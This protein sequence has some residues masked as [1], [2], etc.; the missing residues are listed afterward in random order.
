MNSDRPGITPGDVPQRD[1]PWYPDINDFA[2][3]FDGY[4]EFGGFEPLADF[5]EGARRAWVRDRSLPDNLRE[6]RALL[7]F[8][9]RGFRHTESEPEGDDLEFV[10]AIL[11]AIRNALS[12]GESVG[13]T[14]AVGDR[15]LQHVS[16]VENSRTLSQE[17]THLEDVTAGLKVAGIEP[18][19]PVEV[20]AVSWH[21]NT[22]VT[23]TYRHNDSVHER[24]LYRADEEQLEIVG[25]ANRWTFDAP[26]DDF[27]LA[28]EARRIQLAHLFDPMVAV[29]SSLIEPLPH[30]IQAVYGEMLHRHPLRFLLAD[31]PGAGKTIMAGLYI[32]ELMIRGDVERCLVVA[33]GSLVN[34]WQDELAE[35]FGLKFEILTRDAIEASH[36]GDPF[37]EKPLL[38]ARVDQVA[39]R[40]DL[41]ER[42][43]DTEWDLTVVDEAHKMSAQYFGR[44][45]RETKRYRLGRVLSRISRHFLLMTATP[46][47]GNHESF[48]L[49]LALIDPDRFAGRYRPGA[50]KK[51]DT[52][53]LMRRMIKEKLLRFDGRPLFPE[54]RA[55][56][57]NYDL[58][59]EEMDLYE[60]VTEYVR[61]EMNRAE[62]IKDGDGRR[63]NTVGF[64]LTVLQRRLASSPEAIYQSIRR[65]RG[66]LEDRI[67]EVQRGGRLSDLGLNVDK[68]GY[69]EDEEALED[70]EDL[71]VEELEDLEL[72]VAD[73]ASAA[74]TLTE[75]EAEVSTLKDL[76]KIAARVRASRSDTKW[77]QL[78]DLLSESPEMVDERGARR[79]LIIFTEHRD[80]LNYLVDRLRTYLGSERAVVAIHGGLAR[81]FRREVQL[82]FTQDKDVTI[83]V[84]TDAAGEGINLQRAHLVLNYDLPWNPNRIEQRFGR[85]HRIGQTEVCHM[86][87]LIAGQTR[88]GAVYVRLMEKIDR[89]R[90]A[91][92]GQVYDVLGQAIGGQQL[93][94]LLLDAIRY[95]DQPEVRARLD[96]VIDSTVSDGI[97]RLVQEHALSSEVM[98]AA[99]IDSIRQRMEEA[100]AKRLQP[101]Y[102]QTYFRKAFERFGGSTRDREPG[103][104][105]VMKTPHLIRSQRSRTSGVPLLSRYERITFEKD[106]VSVP[107]SPAAELITPGHRLLDATLAAT[108]DQLGQTLTRGAIL[109]DERP[110]APEPRAL[111]MMEH[112]IADP[113]PSRG[114]GHTVVSRRFEYAELMSDGTSASAS[115]APY[116]DYRPATED[117]I[118]VIRPMLGEE[119][120]SQDLE[121]RAKAL[122]IE[123]SVPTHLQ[124]V[125][126]ELSD[127]VEKV[128]AE[129][130]DRLTK[131]INY[132]DDRAR[133]L[134]EQVAAGKQPRINPERARQRAEELDRRRTE[135]LA[136]LELERNVKALPP[137]VVG[138]ALVVPW[139]W[140]EPTRAYPKQTKAVERR[141]VEAVL[142]AERELGR[143]PEEMPFNNPGFDIKSK[144][145]D[146]DLLFI[147]VKGRIEGA[148]FFTV[149]RNEVLHGLN[150]P[151]RYILALVEVGHE[152]GE[153]LKYVRQPFKGEDE[154]Y[155][156]V[157]S[158][159]FDWS[160][161]WARGAAPESDAE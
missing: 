121:A 86:W 80:T 35:K 77:Q 145:P 43:G 157:T 29:N 69:F 50:H 100:A 156:D 47:S 92:G 19:G 7:F 37:T 23:V 2:H 60:R 109:V 155:F 18:N 5:A 14:A 6:L 51:P 3:R 59:P 129:V 76:E 8:L 154:I 101:H 15:R 90:A 55:Y 38:I 97:P 26:G 114:Q 150:Q 48:Q 70:L 141:A 93:R 82:A 137:V 13:T 149:T 140:F 138:A 41:V 84:A 88:E 125:R 36:T 78:S 10:Q 91:L 81:P 16:D 116:L 34:Q 147:E 146:G 98:A 46:H 106:R 75:L 135:R 79:K 12:G 11:T 123:E 72:E 39:R 151:E 105:E 158:V 21:G 24:I 144:T 136:E 27:R 118:N 111:V 32:K 54:R 52:S 94:S 45:L 134:E 40:D 119:W 112:S 113:R 128:A 25:Y 85:V 9:H 31:D 95:G 89:Q 132:W 63:S 62:R 44:E 68:V 120:L 110:S 160:S 87:N 127:R 115:Y 83:L 74:A 117:E 56:S 142:A 99:E 107:G 96:E 65:R 108:L 58:S 153:R 57:V 1:A 42:L 104:I 64:A 28:A 22:A 143:H 148:A 66:R 53:D 152:G 30:Q 133:E 159:N 126:T 20:V 161:Y 103:R 130:R 33:P 67:E 4:S 131:E 102:I 71:D 49:F 124:E 61:E 139:W 73:Q 17:Q 122:A